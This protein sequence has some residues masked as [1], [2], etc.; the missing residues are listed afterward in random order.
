MELKRVNIVYSGNR[1]AD[2]RGACLDTY[3]LGSAEAR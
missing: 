2:D 1:M 3:Q